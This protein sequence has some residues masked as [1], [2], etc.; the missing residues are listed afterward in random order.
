MFS[1]LLTRTGHTR[2][3]SITWI[4]RDGWEIKQV[5]DS[6]VVR[7]VRCHDWHRVERAL[8]MFRLQVRALES[9]GWV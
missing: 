2:E 1:R 5:E 4:A 7:A 3:Y 9:E 8:A 6:H